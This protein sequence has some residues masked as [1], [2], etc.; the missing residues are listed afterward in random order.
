MPGRPL[1][2][3]EVRA[4][5]TV[6]L[7]LGARVEPRDVDGAPEGTHDFDVLVGDRRIALEVTTVADERHV[8][9]Q[10]VAFSG[11]FPAPGLT[12]R[13]LLGIPNHHGRVMIKA[14]VKEA[15][16]PLRVLESCERLELLDLDDWSLEEEVP[17]V[18]TAGRALRTLGILNA[19][20]YTPA[21]GDEPVLWFVGMGGGLVH[22][23][24]LNP[25][26][27]AKAELKASKLVAADGDERHLWVWI[28]DSGAGAAA[29]MREGM[30]PSE[31][32]MLP[33]G[34]DVVWAATPDLAQVCRAEPLTRW[35]VVGLPDD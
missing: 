20:A 5:L 29:A 32:P 18:A 35:E 7:V 28:A 15:R 23:G 30:I 14:A 22:A 31:P 6:A 33:P 10:N 1:D 26:V 25:L 12:K 4:A 24:R 34:I 27:A 9:M 19:V 8:S 21:E 16:E 2:D 11:A 17:E 3:R 13:W